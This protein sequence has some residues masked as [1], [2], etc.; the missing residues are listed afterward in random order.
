MTTEALV[1]SAPFTVGEQIEARAVHPVTANKVLLMQDDRHLDLPPVPR[2]VRAHGALPAAAASSRSTTR[3][4]GHVAML[5]ENH[6]ELLSLLGGCAYAGLTLFGVNTGLRGEM[7]AG[8]LNQSRARLLV[9]DERLLPEVE[10]V[11][12][13]LTH[14]AA[15][16]I[17]VLR[18]RAA[19]TV[20]AAA[21]LAARASRREVGAAGTSLD[22]PAVDVDAATAT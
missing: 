19:A 5:L 14:V 7:L 12:A 18:D 4:P 21:D 9:V 2:R 6:F 16:N 15:E 10:R 17:L 8:V 3:A 13:E 22:A 1:F 11:R 20:A